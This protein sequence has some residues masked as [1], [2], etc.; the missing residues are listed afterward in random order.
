MYPNGCSIFLDKNKID[1]D[2]QTYE[3][4]IKNKNKKDEIIVLGYMHHVSGQIFTNQIIN[5]YQIYIEGNEEVLNG[6]PNI[7]KGKIDQYYSYQTYS[8]KII[9]EYEDANRKVEYYEH[10]SDYNS[11]IHSKNI[12]SNGKLNFDFSDSP[13]RTALHIQYIDYDD[14]KVAQKSLQPLITGSPKSMLIPSKK[15]MYHFLPLERES[16]NINYYFRPKSLIENFYISFKICT[17]YPEECNFSEK[18]DK[19]PLIDNIGLWYSQPT[20]KAELQLIYISF[21]LPVILVDVSN[22]SILLN[23][24]NLAFPLITD[25]SIVIDSFLL[26]IS[27][28]GKMKISCLLS[29]KNFV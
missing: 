29:F 13:K 8:N 26:K 22:L 1:P 9:I 5:G 23:N 16:T 15:S 18:P 21:S 28:T 10:L 11:F 27:K 6:L 14:I 3:V 24:D 4:I 7:G 2:N 19:I 17:N 20:N 12:D 25:K